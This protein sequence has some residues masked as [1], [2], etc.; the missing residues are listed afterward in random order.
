MES[1]VLNISGRCSG[2]VLQNK[3]F[4]PLNGPILSI[5][6]S[7][8]YKPVSLV[9]V[10]WDKQGLKFVSS[11]C[12]GN[13]LVFSIHKNRFFLVERL[14]SCSSF[15]TFTNDKNQDILAC[16]ADC[17]I[18]S[19]SS[20]DRKV[21]NNFYYHTSSVTYISFDK[22]GR[23]VLS[24]SKDEA[25]LWD[26]STFTVLRVL[27]L[28]KT[29]NIVKVFFIPDKDIIVS[30]FQDSSV[31]F[32]DYK[33]FN[34]I[35]QFI[36]DFETSLL[37]LKC[38]DASSDGQLVACAGK[39]NWFLVWNVTEMMRKCNI[40]LPEHMSVKQINFL[41]S[42]PGSS[43]QYVLSLLNAKG[44]IHI[45]NLKDMEHLHKQTSNAG[46]ITSYASSGKHF[47]LLAVTLQG[48]VELYDL[49]DIVLDAKKASVPKQGKV[50]HMQS[51][52]SKSLQFNL[53]KTKRDI[54]FVDKTKLQ[55]LL[56]SFNEYP[57]K[58][59][60]FIWAQ[61]LEIPHNEDAFNVI[62]QESLNIP[63]SKDY[64]FMNP[65]VKKTF[66]RIMS[67]L[68]CWHPVIHEMDH[69]QCVVFPF[70]KVLHKN[71]IICFEILITLISN[72][73]QN[74]FFFCPFPPYN[75]FCIV[76]NILSFHDLKL[77][78]HFSQNDVS[79]KIYAWSLLQTSFSEVFNKA[80]WLIFWDHV[81]SNG[82]A[83]LLYAVVAYNLLMKDVLMQC[84]RLKEFK[85]CYC[86]HSI[87]AL[88]VVNKTY[89]LQESTPTNIVSDKV[90]GSFVP[91][92][93]GA[94]PSFIQMS[95][96]N[97]N[98][99][100]EESLETLSKKLQKVQNIIQE[101]LIDQVEMLKE[102][103]GEDIYCGSTGDLKNNFFRFEDYM[104]K[105]KIK[106]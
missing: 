57:E 11:D 77:M 12:Q 71:T 69:F 28:K 36:C 9:R 19:L 46:R 74:W 70:I 100:D 105:M 27:T 5:T 63:F 38:I 40:L 4:V 106:T 52:K 68:S 39:A 87:S 60:F 75:I 59:R 17:T 29:V 51:K 91:I 42:Q 83:F 101:N 58:H 55:S 84:S 86:M 1:Y 103:V 53:K 2:S 89:E 94:Y 41:A 35:H 21:K 62:H 32:W 65:G 13:V 22:T 54:S 3:T 30:A 67:M 85:K 50:Y 26:L 78:V 34:C 104:D 6:N 73:C 37:N 31:F 80:Q 82:L 72:W 76:E 98:L 99:E 48:I 96:M 90:I 102:R 10:A 47:Q 44:E 7:S 64:S 93:K 66:L 23:V 97:I 92:P 88:A 49:S 81:F 25:I 20:D 14:N 43:D 24:C 33:N 61:L 79:P 16:L 56:K 15:L 45:Y 8:P 18:V 95:Q